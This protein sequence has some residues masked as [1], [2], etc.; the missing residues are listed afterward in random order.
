MANDLPEKFKI[1]NEQN[2][3]NLAIVVD[4]EGAPYYLSNRTI[5]TRVRYGDPDLRYGDPGIVYGG[6]RPLSNVKDVLSL[7][8]AGLTISQKLEPEQG[9][10]SVSMISLAFV[11]TDQ[12]MTQ[13]VSPGVILPEILGRQ[14]KVRIGYPE[15]SFPEDYV[16][17]L[18]GRISDVQCPPGMVVLQLSDPNIIRR[19]TAFFTATT[20]LLSGITSTD[21]TV[22]VANNADFHRHILGIDGTYDV[23]QPWNQDGTHNPIAPR[24]TGVRTFFKID[25]EWIEYGPLGFGV[26]QFTNVLRGALGTTAAAHDPDADVTAA[27]QIQD[28]AMDMALK[29]MLSGFNGP[30]KT[31]VPVNGF[32]QTFDAI[33]G[34]QP[35]AIILPDHVD[36]VEDHGLSIGDQITITDPI[37]PPNNGL[38]C[39]V[40]RIADF[41]DQPNNLIYVDKDL[42]GYYVGTNPNIPTLALRSQYDTYPINAGNE[43]SPEEV[44]V[45]SHQKLK[46]SYLAD[47][48]YRYRFFIT[49]QDTMKSFMETEIYKPVGAYSLTRRGK[50]SVGYTKPPLA[51]ED[52]IILDEDNLIDPKSIT[53][54]RGVNSRKF[55]NEVDIDYD[56]SDAFS[57]FTSFYR[58]LDA[59]S[60][61]QIGINQQLSIQSKGIHTDLGTPALF[62]KQVQRF[63]TRYRRSATVITAKVNFGTA[64]K[65]EAGDVVALSDNGNLQ[66]ANFGSGDRNLGVQLFE[67]I[68]R[69]LDLKMAVGNL[70]LV[71]GV[72]GLAGD[73]Y[74][75]I[76]PSSVI[77]S[78]ASDHL[79]I[80]DS[81]GALFPGDEMRKWRDYVGQTIAIHDETFTY[82]QECTLNGIDNVNPYKMTIT[83][84][85]TL[86]TDFAGLI[87]DIA[88]YPDS[89]DKYAAGLYKSIHAFLSPQV[90]IVSGASTTQFDVASA[91]AAKFLSGAIVII[92]KDD[93]SVQ[94]TEVHVDQVSGTTITLKEALSFT[95]DNT[96]Y[97]TGIGFPDGQG[98]Y[99]FI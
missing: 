74:A 65:I 32:V 31:G 68:G 43:L 4:I 12:Y 49:D 71:S 80:Q 95:P 15:I 94:S 85:S 54:T 46:N 88:R 14:V 1:F 45:S 91:D 86:P 97:V 3:K 19:Q 44:D 75:T 78:G 87:I 59:D 56:Y 34:D 58:Y 72:G 61:S 66:I 57:D 28:H 25:D 26:N 5:S 77:V 69:D 76:A 6:I 17:V 39:K 24:N 93:F 50:L 99:R 42:V 10:G 73:R 48:A 96:F 52:L 89:I 40:V 79:I 7:D 55:Y 2:A 62:E 41:N 64:I 38:V 23:P 82:Y 9:K 27:L 47:D 81:F 60:L 29:L 63:L 18:R 53:P 51:D 67:V 36:A 11:D 16:T 90:Q 84:L 92:H 37:A 8:G 83:G 30:Y 33:L 35:R 13:L 21:T 20:K 70:T 22:S 98:F